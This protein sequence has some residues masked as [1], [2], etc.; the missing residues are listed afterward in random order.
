MFDDIIAEYSN[1]NGQ[2]YQIK[3]LDLDCYA[4]FRDGVSIHGA[5]TAEDVMRHMAGAIENLA[6]LV[7]RNDPDEL[8]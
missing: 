7:N 5:C 6:Y 3:Y 2:K 8:Y 4:I 1:Q